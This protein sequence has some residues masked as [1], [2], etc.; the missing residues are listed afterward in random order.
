MRVLIV[1][2][3]GTVGGLA[4]VGLWLSWNDLWAWVT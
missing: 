2:L 3:L 1:L 4:V